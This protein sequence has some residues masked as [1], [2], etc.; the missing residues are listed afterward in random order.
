MN[1]F[2]SYCRKEV[3]NDNYLECDECEEYVHI[4]CLKRPGKLI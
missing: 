4:K 1:N 2:C 3:K